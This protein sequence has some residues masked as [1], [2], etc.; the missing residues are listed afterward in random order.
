[1]QFPERIISIKEGDYVLDIGPG[2]TPHPRADV[3]LEKKY[4]NDADF[5]A[6]IGFS[7]KLNTDKKV[8]YYEGNVFPFKDKEFDYVIC[9]HVIE[10]I[11]DIESFIAEILRIGKAGYIEFPTI[12]YEYLFNFDV[13]INILLYKDNTIN[14]IKKSETKL[15]IFKEIQKFYYST[16]EKKYFWYIDTFKN[17]M[18]QGY[19]WVETINLK[20]VKSLNELCDNNDLPE[21]TDYNKVSVI[22]RIKN[23]SFFTF[24]KY[25]K[26]TKKII[27]LIVNRCLQ[28]FGLLEL[29]NSILN[30]YY[31]AIKTI[32]LKKEFETDL[33]KFLQS[34]SKTNKRFELNP[35]EIKPFLHDKTSNTGFD[36]HYIYHP[37]WAARILNQRKPSFHIDISSTLHFSTIVSAFIPVHF[38]DYRPAEINL[39]NFKSDKINLLSLPFENNSVESISCMHTVEHIGLGR[40]GDNVDYNAD[41][42]AIKELKRVLKIG[43]TLLFVV[44]IGKS[45]IIFNAH[46]IY[47]YDQIIN[48]FDDLHL[49]DFSIVTDCCNKNEFIRNSTK[50]IADEQNYGCGCFCFTKL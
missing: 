16:L 36:S 29:F 42:K 35:K 6:Q 4:E 34:A 11:E 40:Y 13:H 14:W 23:K 50:K 21:I 41:L 19:E 37:A 32:K 49:V 28:L 9:S 47:D 10:H 30:K 38:Y 3:L 43:G 45:K 39:D 44:P 18:F 26:K 8:V 7:G 2:S 31:T 5:D 1:M 12:Y 48:L 17:Y 15:D 22:P 33:K 46:R 24:F 20:K 25:K 27:M